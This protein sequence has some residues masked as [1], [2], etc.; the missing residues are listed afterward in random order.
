MAGG[1][2]KLPKNKGFDFSPRYYNE[3]KEA[4]E[5]RYER[6]KAEIEEEKKLKE[7]PDYEHRLRGQMRG[8]LRERQR[9]NR[10]STLRLLIILL[11]LL[12]LCYYF[13]IKGLL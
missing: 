10:R 12:A 11:A 6:I 3:Q 9:G 4:M 1:F 2:V 8:L 5:E 7:D 13:F